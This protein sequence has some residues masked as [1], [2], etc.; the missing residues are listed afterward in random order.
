MSS[1]QK[2]DNQ[3]NMELV[4]ELMSSGEN[5]AESEC[6]HGA[7]GKKFDDIRIGPE[8]SRSIS[9]DLLGFTSMCDELKELKEKG[10]YSDKS[11]HHGE[12][13]LLF[14][15]KKECCFSKIDLVPDIIIEEEHEVTED[16]LDV[17]RR[18]YIF[19]QK[20]EF[21][22][23]APKAVDRALNFGSTERKLSK[24]SQAQLN[25]WLRGLE[26]H[27]EQRADGEIYFFDRIWI[28]S[29]GDMSLHALSLKRTPENPQDFLKQ[30]PEI[31][32]G[33][34]KNGDQVGYFLLFVRTTK[35]RSCQRYMST[36]FER[37]HGLCRSVYH[38]MDRGGRFHVTLW[39]LFRK[40]GYKID[41]SYSLPP[42]DRDGQICEEAKAEEDS[43]SSSSLENSRKELSKPGR[44]DQFR[45][46]YPIFSPEP[47]LRQRSNGSLEEQGSFNGEDTK[48]YRG[49]NSSDGG[50]TGDG[51]KIAGGVIGSGGGIELVSMDG[52]L[53]DGIL[54]DVVDRM[55][56]RLTDQHGEKMSPPLRV[57]VYLMRKVQSVR[58]IQIH[59]APPRQGWDRIWREFI[60]I[61]EK[62]PYDD[63]L[64]HEYVSLASELIKPTMDDRLKRAHQQLSYLTA[65]LTN[66]NI[67]PWGNYIKEEGE[68]D[69]HWVLRYK[70]ED[71]MAN[72]MMEK[73]H[74]LNRLMEILGQ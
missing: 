29:I 70:F 31:P 56:S 62:G 61:P 5:V 13:L 49:S 41:M 21:E 3:H 1:V 65:P 12:H 34:G 20:E 53:L 25:E 43:I 28:P 48:K 15:K 57:P 11:S 63:P 73:K 8:I 55:Y 16:N 35:P 24:G 33:N 66:N 32:D 50:N 59:L 45:I 64:S 2:Q 69:L 67:P 4:L 46:K 60:Q 71:D 51:V 17:S 23:L 38:F 40:L 36:R 74:H 22:L 37:V 30:Q 6:G 9:S 14:V 54:R 72:F 39:Q 19:D 10:F 68:E 44:E 47:V 26:R 52:L 42:S 18:R 7:D 27:F 58:Q